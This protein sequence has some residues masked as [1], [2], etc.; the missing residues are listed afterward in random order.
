[1]SRSE[2]TVKKNPERDPTMDLLG[3]EAAGDATWRSW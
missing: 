3:E 1:M 2:A